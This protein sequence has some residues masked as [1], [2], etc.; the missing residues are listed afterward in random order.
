[1]IT[2][3]RPFL[4]LACLGVAGCTMDPMPQAGI[5]PSPK[6]DGLYKG[7]AVL[8][9]DMSTACTGPAGGIHNASFVVK[10]GYIH[11][12]TGYTFPY[13]QHHVYVPVAPNGKFQDSWLSWMLTGK[14]TGNHMT[15]FATSTTCGSQ[16]SLTKVASLS[17]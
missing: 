1:M 15:A 6:Y 8:T 14:I 10:N 7:T 3:T 17:G 2:K 5:V 13:N 12:A 9:Q 11:W 16:L 4:A